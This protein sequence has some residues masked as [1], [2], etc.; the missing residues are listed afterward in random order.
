MPGTTIRARWGCSNTSHRLHAS[1][2]SV[3]L[4]S[5]LWRNRKVQKAPKI[6]ISSSCCRAAITKSGRSSIASRWGGCEFGCPSL[7]FLRQMITPRCSVL[8]QRELPR[9]FPESI[10]SEEEQKIDAVP[11]YDPSCNL[12]D[13]RLPDLQ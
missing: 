4:R 13:N 9:F 6:S 8:I 11:V 7:S 1:R 12:G 10:S 5:S 2:G 3:L